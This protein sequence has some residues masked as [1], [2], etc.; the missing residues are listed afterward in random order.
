MADNMIRH[1]M[2]F[3]YFYFSNKSPKTAKIKIKLLLVSAK[4]GCDV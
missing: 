3:I 1:H 4:I 2:T